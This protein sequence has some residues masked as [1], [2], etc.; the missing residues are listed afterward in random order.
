MLKFGVIMDPIESINP[1]KDTTFSLISALQKRCRV[2]YIFPRTMCLV[3][4]KVKAKVSKIKVFKNKTN[5]YQLSEKRLINLN[6]FNA[7]LFRVDPPVDIDYIQLTYLLD[8]VE[9]N[10][11]LLISSPQSLRDFNEKM[12][13]INLSYKKVPTIITSNIKTIKE[14]IKKNKK[15]VIKPLN[16]MGGKDVYLIPNKNI[17]IDILLNDLTQGEKKLIVSQKYLAQIKNGDTRVIIYNGIVHGK[18]LV[19][20]PPKNDF[21][22]NLSFGGKYEVRNLPAKHKKYLAE[23]AEFL[24]MNRIYLAG[25]DMIGDFI[26]EINITSPTGIQEIER[27]CNSSLSED[28]AN[29]FINIA[30]S[31]YN[32][33]Y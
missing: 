17:D 4:E 23:V 2:E 16:F 15:I 9:K 10:G 24:K 11:T 3:D 25:V 22:A 20:F 31:F 21:R 12:L 19:R 33:D 14:F 27:E 5:Y 8:Q 28:I 18:V 1:K 13:G 32:H 26:T 30:Q 7:I 29:E 6:S